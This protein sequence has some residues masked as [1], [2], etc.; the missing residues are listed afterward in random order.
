VTKVD[1]GVGAGFP[2][3]VEEVGD[4]GK[5]ISVFLGD[6]VEPAVVHAQSETSV[7]F[8]HEE[9]RSSV[10]RIGGSDETAPN[11]VFNEGSEGTQLRRREGVHATRRRSLTFLKVDFEVVRAM[12]RE[13]FRFTLAEDV[14]ELVVFLRNTGEVDRVSGR[15]RGFARER[16]LCKIELETLRA[17]EAT[18]T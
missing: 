3:G 7:F 6:L 11:V 5:G 10:R 16:F 14:G 15:G 18:S 12:F 1:F 13:C 9:D 4:E 8:P 2:R 17:G